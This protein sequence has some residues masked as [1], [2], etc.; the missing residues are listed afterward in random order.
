MKICSITFCSIPFVSPFV[1]LQ[2]NLYTD[3]TTLF[4]KKPSGGTPKKGLNE[5]P[6][7]RWEN[8]QIRVANY[9]GPSAVSLFF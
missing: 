1:S 6:K 5:N 7:E 2:Y 9:R 4:T 3:H 8:K